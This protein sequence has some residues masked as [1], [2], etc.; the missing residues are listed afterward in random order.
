VLVRLGN[1]S[2]SEAWNDE[3]FISEVLAALPK[4]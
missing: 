2:Y 1:S 4:P 3:K